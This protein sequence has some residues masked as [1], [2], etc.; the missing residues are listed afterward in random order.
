VRT[1]RE[2]VLAD[3][4]D[5][6]AQHPLIKVTS[7]EGAKGLSA[8]RVFIVGLHDGDLPR[9]P[10]VIKDI[11]ICRFVVGLTRTKKKCTLI[12]TRNFAGKRKV[13]SCFLNW[14]N[15]QRFHRILVDAAYWRR[16]DA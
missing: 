12:H 3:N 11:E 13:S 9:D 8:Q 6:G 7:F 16:P 14:I 5:A 2:K 1:E 4:R 10:E 15:R